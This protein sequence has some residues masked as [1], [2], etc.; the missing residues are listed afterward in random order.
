MIKMS[1]KLLIIL[2]HSII[3][4]LRAEY[5]VQSEKMNSFSFTN[6]IHSP[7]SKCTQSLI[8]QQTSEMTERRPSRPKHVGMF[9]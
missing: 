3:L 6:L 5:A 4:E 8:V 9:M 1:M 7:L 2:R